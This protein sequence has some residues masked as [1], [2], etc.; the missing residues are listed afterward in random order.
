MPTMLDYKVAT[1]RTIADF[2]NECG[3][4]LMSNYV[5]VGGIFVIKTK[6]TDEES[7]ITSTFYEYFQAFI[8]E[9]SDL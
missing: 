2:E 1:G 7:G 4:A 3:I 6:A 9:K 8:Y 5:P